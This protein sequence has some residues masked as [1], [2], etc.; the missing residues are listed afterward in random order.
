MA[1]GRIVRAPQ[2]IAKA[3]YSQGFAMDAP[4]WVLRER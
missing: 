4:E 1:S 3:G 2:D